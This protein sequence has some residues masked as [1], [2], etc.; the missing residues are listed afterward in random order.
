MAQSE[1]FDIRALCLD[2]DG[3]LTD[4]RVYWDD[5]GSGARTFHVHDGFA[6]RWFQKLGGLIILC[7]GKTSA[8]VAVRARELGI[9]EVIQGSADKVA[10]VR[11]VLARHGLRLS[12]LAMMGDDLPDVPLMRCCGLAIAPANAVAEARAAARVVTVR[13]GGDGAVREAV[14]HILRALGR[15]HEVLGHYGIKPGTA[16]TR[17]AA[18]VG[19]ES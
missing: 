2:V 16:T 1:P 15:W 8:A 11:A 19:A 4:G 14:E 7:S 9:D 17:P 6:L 3:V 13:A 12:Q 5:A 18:D 10:D